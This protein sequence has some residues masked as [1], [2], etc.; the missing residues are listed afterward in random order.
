MK[1]SLRILLVLSSLLLLTSCKKKE[2]AP[3]Y[4]LTAYT[5]DQLQMGNYYVKSGESYYLLAKG[6]M[7]TEENGSAIATKVDEHRVVW[8]ADD[9]VEIPTLYEEDELIYVTSSSVPNSYI[10]ERYKD[11]GYTIGIKNLE[12]TDS[13]KY[14]FTKNKESIQPISNAATMFGQFENDT[15]IN[16]DKIGGTTINETNVS[17]CGSI[18]GL[19][20]GE[21]YNVD[22]YVGTNFNALEVKAD[23][24]VFNSFEVYES[25]TY[26]LS[27][28]GYA[29]ITIPDYFKS[30]FYYLNGMGLFRY[31]KASRIDGAN[32][33]DF[34]E[35]YYIGYD[36]DGNMITADDIADGD[37]A[38]SSDTKEEDFTKEWIQ[39]FTLD[40]SQERMDVRVT[41]SDIINIVN[42]QKVK[43]ESDE[44]AA[45]PLVILIG[46]DGEG[47]EFTEDERMDNSLVC[48]VEMPL[49]G[50]W[51]ISIKDMDNR[52][53]ETSTEFVSGSAD[54]LVH[55]GSGS[56]DMT[57]YLD[58]NLI[59]G[60]FLFTWENKERAAD[61]VVET[62]TGER[63][64]K[65]INPIDVYDEGYGYL[66]L[67]VGNV[68][69][70]N[71]KITVTGED[72]GRIRWNYKEIYESTN[73]MEDEA[74][75]QENYLP[76]EDKFLNGTDT[77]QTNKTEQTNQTSQNNQSSQTDTDSNDSDI[78]IP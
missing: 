64:G 36:D 46:P 55:T 78:I 38:S 70:G 65:Q 27:Q 23:T 48:S 24:R 32:N 67:H 13:G 29:V 54:N 8:F 77:T 6:T 66:D 76:I 53:F 72:L 30:G 5:A 61:I 60:L 56:A 31:A 17:P 4:Q 10:W 47:Y 39:K 25:S 59:D 16:I 71:Y 15:A 3:V 26:Q 14:I 57:V 44:E 51:T 63:F 20:Q 45:T 1:K 35:P 11:Y 62:P 69:S 2:E 28:E 73:K 41:Y 49:S 34:N 74:A 68:I 50:E 21:L 19:G 52:T 7:S 9:E 22:T 18:L 42:G 33:I 58:Q 37:T 12:K 75:Q 40:H 43:L